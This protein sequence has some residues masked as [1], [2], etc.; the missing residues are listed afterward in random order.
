MKKGNEI[1]IRN[2]M[3]EEEQSMD[4][5]NGGTT[6]TYIS[7]MCICAHILLSNSKKL[8][9]M[10]KLIEILE[11]NLMKTYILVEN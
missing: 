3:R 6:S 11:G 2:E 4:D 1:K 8:K 7:Y 10:E 9:K 5:G